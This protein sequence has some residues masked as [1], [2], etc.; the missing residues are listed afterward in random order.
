MTDDSHSGAS[1]KEPEPT[2]AAAPPI[3]SDS[4]SKTQLKKLP[5][6]SSPHWSQLSPLPPAKRATLQRYVA[7]FFNQTL[8]RPSRTMS[9]MSLFSRLP[10]WLKLAPQARKIG[11][12][13][14]GE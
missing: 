14:A 6:S 13:F 5:T 4:H 8:Q 3:S 2:P 10:V 11:D 1:G 7:N 12:D 9:H